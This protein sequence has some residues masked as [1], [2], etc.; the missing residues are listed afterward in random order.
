LNVHPPLPGR[1]TAALSRAVV[2][3]YYREQT[4]K[5]LAGAKRS[6]A[7]RGIVCKEVGLIGDPGAA[8]ASYAAK[9]KFSLVIMGS[10][11]QGALRNLVLGSVASKVLAGCKVPALI[12][13]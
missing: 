10:H 8:I 13:R 11:G 12:V 4:R 2:N 6:L 3:R 7:R 1:A 5:A 9:G